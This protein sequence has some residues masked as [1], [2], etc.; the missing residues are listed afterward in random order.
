M[1]AS[2]SNQNISSSDQSAR[3]V[4]T[5][6]GPLKNLV[7]GWEMLGSRSKSPIRDV[8]AT[9]NA[10]A[11]AGYSLS[12]SPMTS[13]TSKSAALREQFFLTPPSPSS[14]Q[15]NIP[16]TPTT[17]TY[18]GLSYRFAGAERL[19][20]RQKIY[21]SVSPD[22]KAEN[23]SVSCKLIKLSFD[24]KR[25]CQNYLIASIIGIKNICLN[26]SFVICV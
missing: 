4:P 17:P 10:P 11:N 2:N 25:N 18:G 14:S 21:E 3:N 13:S 23:T 12:T 26:D 20:Q 15:S 9:P 8:W 22:A 6:L 5:D 19:A 1:I 7:A 16:H 24:S